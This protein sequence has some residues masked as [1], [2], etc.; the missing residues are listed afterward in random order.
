MEERTV[1]SIDNEVIIMSIMKDEILATP[2]LLE[3]ALPVY[4]PIVETLARGILASSARSIYTASRG[5]SA[6]ATAYFQY[7]CD[8]LTPYSC[9]ALQPSVVTLMGGKPDLRDGVYLAVSQGGRGADIRMMTEYA[10]S[11]GIPAV[12]VTNEEDSPL[13]QLGDVLIP[14]SMG[15]ERSMAATKTYSAQM[16][17]LGLLAH[18]LSGKS[19]DLSHIPGLFRQAL[20]ETEKTVSH[21][22]HYVSSRSCFVLARGALLPVAKELCCKLQETCLINATPYSA[23]DFLHG[24]FSLIEPGVQVI[25]FHRADET[26][27]STEDMYRRMT[28]NGAQ[29][30]VFTDSPEFARDKEYALCLPG[31]NWMDAPF[32][33]AAASQLFACHLADQRGTNPD[34]SRNLNKYTITV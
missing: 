22:N 32:A 4:T 11:C 30:T 1:F 3:A 14:L 8:V 5:T 29:V 9:K 19:R 20:E 25:L 2:A 6:N 12:S 31:S 7:L 27:A 18:A 10:R 15:L 23:A 21:W 17:A 13:A 24:P 26:A 28:D 16:L 34:T 33:F